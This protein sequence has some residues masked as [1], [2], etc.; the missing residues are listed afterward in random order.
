MSNS[1][2]TTFLDSFLP[3]L[4]PHSCAPVCSPSFI[5]VILLSFLRPCKKPEILVGRKQGRS[6]G[7]GAAHCSP[8]SGPPPPHAASWNIVLISRDAKQTQRRNYKHQRQRPINSWIINSSCADGPSGPVMREAAWGLD[9][10]WA[11][12]WG[13][14][15]ASRPSTTSCHELGS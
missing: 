15:S 7:T 12:H 5:D 14:P 10:A 4:P 13:L 3:P 11:G 8:S 1:Q 6:W 9:G 2:W